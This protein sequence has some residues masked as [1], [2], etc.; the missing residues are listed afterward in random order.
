MFP[1][2]ESAALATFIGIWWR[3]VSVRRIEREVVNLWKLTVIA[4]VLGVGLLAASFLTP[5]MA[6]S[7]GS[8][9]LDVR[10]VSSER[11]KYYGDIQAG[12]FQNISRDAVPVKI[13]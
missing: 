4:L 12:L 13:S 1:Q 9:I 11:W 8:G 2:A 6:L 5:N 3:H 7:A 10:L